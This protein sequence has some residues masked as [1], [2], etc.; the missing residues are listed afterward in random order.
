MVVP[1]QTG[2]GCPVG[3]GRFISSAGIANGTGTVDFAPVI[4]EIG[5]TFGFV[6]IPFVSSI[7][8][9]ASDTTY[10]KSDFT[11]LPP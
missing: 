2:S 7:A 11:S 6:A 4:C 5:L 3:I 8:E 10:R 1:A 9:N